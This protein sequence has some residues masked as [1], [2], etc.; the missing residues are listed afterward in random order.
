MRKASFKSNHGYFDQEL[1]NY[2]TFI[3]RLIE[4]AVRT[5]DARCAL[6]EAFILRCAASWE[7]LVDED[8]ITSLNRDSSQYSQ[9]LDLRL[10]KLLSYDECKAM[11]H[12]IAR[13]QNP[14]PAVRPTNRSKID[15][16]L[17][18]RNCV[19]YRS[20]FAWRKFERMMK[21]T[22]LYKR[23]PEPSGFK[24]AVEN[25]RSRWEG[26]LGFFLQASKDMLASV[27]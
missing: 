7:S 22:C 2:G 10:R 5:K 3:K 13:N 25:G 26:Y 8:I 27:S 24:N 1:T 23:V 16:F 12:G 18:A 15:E 17:T 6:V 14:F 11:L 20:D 21:G 4:N 19:A 9:A